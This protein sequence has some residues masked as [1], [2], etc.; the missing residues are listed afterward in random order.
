M[1]GRINAHHYTT[2]GEMIKKNRELANIT[3]SQLGILTGLSKGVISK[4]ELGETKRPELKTIKAI[5]TVLTIPYQEIVEYYTEVEQRV[6]ALHELLLEVIEFSNIPLVSKVAL[7][8][9]QSPQGE[10]MGTL[11][12]L[13]QLANT[14]EKIEIKLLLYSIMIKYARERGIPSYVAK[15]LLHTYLLERQDLKRLEETFKNGEELLHYIDF[16]SMEERITFYFR[17]GLHAHNTKKYEQCIQLCESGLKEDKSTSELKAR[18]YLA[19]INSYLISGHYDAVESH[20]PVYET[21]PYGFVEESSKLTK[22]IVKA[23]KREYQTAIPMLNQLFQEISAHSRIHVANELMQIY[24]HMEDMDAIARLLDREKE[25]LSFEATTPYQHS[26]LGEYYRY[27]GAYHL[28][29]GRFEAGKS[30]YLQSMLAY[31]EIMAHEEI[32]ECMNDLLFF[33]AAHGK[34]IELHS[35]QK[36]SEVYNRIC[37]NKGKNGGDVRIWGKVLEFSR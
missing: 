16:L 28:K 7:K 4:I 31:G 21:F 36:L 18:A 30:S 11:D 19:M 8:L 12:R 13:F 5:A 34:V 20:L 10:T 1:E 37:K 26:S 29:A 25:I 24:F 22:A 3:I 14:V 2:I 23:R 9:L 35:V 27:K 15:G 17:L 33:Y 32:T 6:E